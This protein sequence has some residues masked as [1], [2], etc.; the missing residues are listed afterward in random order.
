[1][2][3]LFC[4]VIIITSFKYLE[5]QDLIRNGG[6]ELPFD[7]NTTNFTLDDPKLPLYRGSFNK[8][9]HG[10]VVKYWFGFNFLDEGSNQQDPILFDSRWDCSNPT[11]ATYLGLNC[12]SQ[13]DTYGDIGI[14]DNYFGTQ[15]HRSPYDGV[16]IIGRYAGIHTSIGQNHGIK[17]QLTEPI[18]C[19]KAYDLSFWAVKKGGSNVKVHVRFSESGKWSDPIPYNEAGH[20]DYEVEVTETTSWQHITEHFNFPSSEAG[21]TVW[22]MI[23]L[24]KGGLA[25]GRLLLDDFSFQKTFC[26][27]Q[28]KCSSTIDCIDVS[29]N[30]SHSDTDPFRISGLEEVS[31]LN[32]EFYTIQGGFLQSINTYSVHNPAFSWIWDGKNA[33]GSYV[34]NANYI[35]K[36]TLSNDCNTKEYSGNF[37]VIYPSVYINPGYTYDGNSYDRPPIPCCQYAPDIVL[38]NVLIAPGAEYYAN[39][40]ITINNNVYIPDGSNVV[41]QAAGL[42]EVGT[43][44]VL[45]G[46]TVLQ[47]EPCNKS[48]FFN[49]GNSTPLDLTKNR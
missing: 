7:P 12:S 26:N 21:K 28:N 19:D 25:E 1:M 3:F 5:A 38:D 4:I 23:S 44:V 37:T 40:T 43:G 24:T 39:G 16:N 33:A 32:V 11:T 30:E 47:L 9:P 41:F 46:S 8:Y 29:I 48:A 2:K 17:T 31:E 27:P 20:I 22:I 18:A 10:I 13:I 15:D 49:G 14:P 34:A 45:N 36:A 35:Y 42:I 6:F